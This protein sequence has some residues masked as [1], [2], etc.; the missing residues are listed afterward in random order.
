MQI[1]WQDDYKML[2]SAIL[3]AFGIIV[4]FSLN[5][6][7][8]FAVT[9]GFS[10]L[11]FA[12]FLRFYG[13]AAILHH[14]ALAMLCLSLGFVSAHFHSERLSA[15]ILSSNQDFYT[16][17]ATV[18]T[19][20]IDSDNN[21]KIL[22]TDLDIPT[23]SL[24]QTPKKVS[25]LVRTAYPQDLKNADRIML[26]AVMSAP[27]GAMY[28]AGFNFA[29]QS[30]FRQIGGTGFVVSAITR[31]EPTMV[32][33]DVSFIS[34][35]R[36][37][38]REKLQSGLKTQESK[39]LGVALLTGDRSLIPEEV[40]YTMRDAGLAHILAISGLHMGLVAASI[41]FFIE[42]IFALIPK[43]ALR[44]PPAKIAAVV[45]WLAALG[46]LLLSGGAV[47]TLRAFIMVSVVLMAVVFDRRVL[48]LRS[49]AIAALLIMI[50]DPF[51]VMSVGFQMSFA[52]VIALIIA[53]D[54]FGRS[55]IFGDF[56]KHNQPLSMAA[57]VGG[58]II[59]SL[60]TTLVAEFAIAP[61]VLYHFQT[62]VLYGLLANFVAIPLLTFWI[63]PLALITLV[64]MPFGLE[65][66]ALVPLDA[67]LNA[68][69]YLAKTVANLDGATAHFPILPDSFLA[70][71]IV[72]GLAFV[73]IRSWHGASIAI[74]GLFSMLWI[75]MNATPKDIYINEDGK[76]FA[77]I[78][79]QGNLAFNTGR[80]SFMKEAWQRANGEAVVASNPLPRLERICDEERCLYKSDTGMMISVVESLEQ[81]M[82]DCGRIPIVIA[83]TVSGRFCKGQS[84]V[85]DRGWLSKGPLTLTQKSNETF[86][87][88][89]TKN[90]T[91]KRPWHF[92]Q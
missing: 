17:E 37:L 38:I 49:V 88:E 91:D 92:S 73:L 75:I 12:L 52:A 31:L 14:S 68:M 4:Y 43:I 8:P 51:A 32:E 29:R 39:G 71:A 46:Y 61:F 87:I 34:N 2:V 44:V 76:T 65:G 89:T 79:K 67:G 85:L 80:H 42:A 40:V 50:F 16:L 55:L 78:N 13:R 33:T 45:A 18:E 72:S 19:L 54:R 23:L 82:A 25:L 3:F 1:L 74:I 62:I 26:D 15:P 56:R 53:Y 77:V 9:L 48:S 35:L 58:F 22:L 47:S 57:K 86:K 64:L 69:A 6:Q 24:A 21:V 27:S 5:S 59:A 60:M 36:A 11:T 81:L 41:F 28:P 84:L 20:T 70:I 30:W 10:V 90:A 7:P 83:P 66:I 63:M